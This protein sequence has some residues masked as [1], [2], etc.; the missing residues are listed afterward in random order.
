[1]N[2]ANNPYSTMTILG[3]RFALYFPIFGAI[4]RLWGFESVDRKNMNR[5]M[6]KG[7]NLGIVPGGY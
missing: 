5:L 3:S 1:M 2:V 7:T 6:D 4:L